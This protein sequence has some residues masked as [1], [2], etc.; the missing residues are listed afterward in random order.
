MGQDGRWERTQAKRG[1]QSGLLRE[2]APSS[3]NSSWTSDQG[4][5]QTLRLGSSKCRAFIQRWDPLGLSLFPVLR[6]SQV[7]CTRKKK[8]RCAFTLGILLYILTENLYTL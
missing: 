3:A 2:L 5:M 4:W 6:K 8:K 7:T 1:L